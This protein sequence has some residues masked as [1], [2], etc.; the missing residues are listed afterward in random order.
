MLRLL[1]LLTNDYICENIII[2]Y[3]ISGGL[4]VYKQTTTS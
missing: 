1:S 4:V 3:N 2:K